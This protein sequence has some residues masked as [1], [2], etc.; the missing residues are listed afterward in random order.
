MLCDSVRKAGHQDYCFVRDVEKIDDPK[1]L[2]ERALAEIK[3]SDCLLID[4]SDAPS[5]GRVL[6]TGIA[7]ALRIPVVVVAKTGTTFKDIFSGV[8]DYIIF[9]DH[10]GDITSSLQKLQL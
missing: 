1:A 8:S 5:G 9:Y 6:E 2:W 10:Y 4:V 7:F 3:K